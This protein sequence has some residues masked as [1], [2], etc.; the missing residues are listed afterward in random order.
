MSN[1]RQPNTETLGHAFLRKLSL[2]TIKA[3]NTT[4]K[5]L[6]PEKIAYY[7]LNKKREDIMNIE[8]K[9]NITLVIESDTSLALGESRIIC[10]A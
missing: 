5:A 1:E 6:V 9:R 4:V 7:L 10:D 8:A 3:D 2:E